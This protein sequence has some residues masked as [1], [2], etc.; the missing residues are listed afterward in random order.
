MDFSGEQRQ[1]LDKKS[2]IV[3]STRYRGE[4]EEHGVVMAKGME[5]CILVYPKNEWENFV[6]KVKSSPLTKKGRMFNRLFRGGADKTPTVDNQGR[7]VIPPYLREYAKLNKEVVIVGVGTNLEIWDKD[8][9]EE[10]IRAA[11]EE[12]EEI[13]ESLESEELGF[14]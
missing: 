2:R 7:V 4:F 3:L 13:A 1:S 11:E 9:W 10:Y 14:Q 12:Y 6:G 8:R 5:G